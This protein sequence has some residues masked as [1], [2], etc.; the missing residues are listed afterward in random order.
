M[1]VET[2]KK[3]KGPKG[4]VTVD[5][6]QCKGCGFCIEF[7]PTDVFVFSEEYNS[8]G[9]HFPVVKND[10][11]CTGCDQCGAYCPDFAVF[12]TRFAKKK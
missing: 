1:A 3:T 10:E 7:C 8:H 9:Y 2:A 11:K 12:G 5:N 6:E 4:F